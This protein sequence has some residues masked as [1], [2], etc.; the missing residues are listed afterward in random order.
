MKINNRLNYSLLMYLVS[1]EHSS[2]L[3]D[4]FLFQ[5]IVD[6]LEIKGFLLGVFH[7]SIFLLS[8]TRAIL[9]QNRL[10]I[11]I[12]LSELHPGNLLYECRVL[13]FLLFTTLTSRFEDPK[14]GVAGNR[15]ISAFFPRFPRLIALV[16]EEMFFFAFLKTPLLFAAAEV[17]CWPVVAH[18]DES[19]QGKEGRLW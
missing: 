8:T 19:S 7:L 5:G 6:F 1:S 12:F 17:L 14:N 11:F 16:E 9:L 15:N 4:G 13:R 3:L 2:R 10:L 18:S